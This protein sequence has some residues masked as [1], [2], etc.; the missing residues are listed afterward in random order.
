MIDMRF[1]SYQVYMYMYYIVI[2]SAWRKFHT[3]KGNT[4][5]IAGK[6]GLMSTSKMAKQKSCEDTVYFIK[7]IYIQLTETVSFQI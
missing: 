3:F 6:M 4:F 5:F 7:F 2:F 1:F